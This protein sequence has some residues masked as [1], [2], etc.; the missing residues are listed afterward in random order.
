MNTKPGRARY[1]AFPDANGWYV[2]LEYA[3]GHHRKPLLRNSMS[4]DEAR[5]EARRRN[6]LIWGAEE[7]KKP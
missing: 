7:D 6:E 2:A 3:D 4:K 5:Q 1:R